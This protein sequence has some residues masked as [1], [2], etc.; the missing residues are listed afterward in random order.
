MINYELARVAQQELGLYHFTGKR[1]ATTITAIYNAW[2][3]KH[4]EDLGEQEHQYIQVFGESP[5]HDAEFKTLMIRSFMRDSRNYDNHKWL[6][7]NLK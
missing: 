4:M 6:T 7:D 1:Q 5:D 2:V 3:G